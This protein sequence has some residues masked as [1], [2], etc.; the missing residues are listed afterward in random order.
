[1]EDKKKSKKLYI[2]KSHMNIDA[3]ELKKKKKK[4][5]N[6]IKRHIKRF[7]NLVGDLSQECKVDLTSKN[8]SR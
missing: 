4:L 3:E 6:S 1:M 2:K 8:Q 7:I 5:V